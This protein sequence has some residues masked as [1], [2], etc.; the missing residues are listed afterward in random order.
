MVDK[1]SVKQ[2]EYVHALRINEIIDEA[3]IPIKKVS[4]Q[5]AEYVY[6]L[7]INEII[8]ALNLPIVKISVQQPEYTT[9][10]RINDII[11]AISV[12][13][14]WAY[15]FDGVDDRAVL[16][17]R[18]VNI[19]GANTFEFWTPPLLTP[20]QTIIAQN[21]TSTGALMEFRLFIGGSGTLEVTFGGSITAIATVVQGL[22][23]ATRYGLSFVG[24]NFDLRTGHLGGQILRS[25]TFTTGE[26]REPSAPT[27]ISARQNGVGSFTQFFQGPQYDIKINGVLWP[28]A[29]RNQANQTSIPAGD[30]MTLVN[31]TSDR[32]QEVPI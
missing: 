9:A 27:I 15:N 14:R 29:D 18:V 31:T 19:D 4:V 30:D 2:P 8:D 5:Q 13:T 24:S 3:N 16:A 32:W 25:G 11:D 17:R 20:G 23:P 7:K 10:L 22:T 1:I 21:I 12:T 28:M 26:A 6:A